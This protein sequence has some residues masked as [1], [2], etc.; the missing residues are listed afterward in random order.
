MEM[1]KVIS[2]VLVFLALVLAAPAV[3]APEPGIT[4]DPFTNYLLV[5]VL[6]NGREVEVATFA[7]TSWDSQEQLIRATAFQAA[8]Q[9]RTNN[10]SWVL[11][12]YGPIDPPLTYWT[13]D[14][15]IWTSA[16]LP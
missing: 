16:L 2:L 5:R 1:K 14:D 12:M 10:P 3:A 4:A 7:V 13:D 9:Q 15:R 8:R 6:P 11:I